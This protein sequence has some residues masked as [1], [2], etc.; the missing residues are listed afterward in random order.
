MIAT[1]GTKGLQSCSILQPED[2]KPCFPVEGCRGIVKYV[3]LLIQTSCED[4]GQ[5]PDN[6]LNRDVSTDWGRDWEEGE[7]GLRD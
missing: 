1:E 3:D 7:E 2:F 6:Y 4:S 5:H